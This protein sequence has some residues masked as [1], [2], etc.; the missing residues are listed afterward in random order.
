MSFFVVQ[1]QTEPIAVQLFRDNQP[2]DLSG[3]PADSVTLVLRRQD[4]TI[5]DTTG[6]VEILQAATGKVRYNPGAADFSSAGTYV[7]RF[8]VVDGAGKIGFWPNRG[9]DQWI[10][11]TTPVATA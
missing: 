3:L 11:G 5:V 1:G 10:V 7:G 9:I 6:D 4:G 8:R 2:V